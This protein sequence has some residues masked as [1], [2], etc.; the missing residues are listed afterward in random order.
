MKIIVSCRHRSMTKPHAQHTIYTNSQSPS[1]RSRWKHPLHHQ[2]KSI[3]L[4]LAFFLI[5]LSFFFVSPA[6]SYR[7]HY[8]PKCN[9][10]FVQVP[11]CLVCLYHTCS[12]SCKRG[13][14]LSLPPHLSQWEIL[15]T[16]IAHWSWG[17]CCVYYYTICMT[18]LQLQVVPEDTN[19]TCCHNTPLPKVNWAFFYTAE[20]ATHPH[21]ALTRAAEKQGDESAQGPSLFYMGKQECI[22]LSILKCF[23]RRCMRNGLIFSQHKMDD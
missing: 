12:L 9:Q 6:G 5:Y 18:I 13:P 3:I 8:L 10:L 4:L 17:N 19:Q 16:S 15:W 21:T 23:I 14:T 20:L 11:A 22:H 1:A 2:T 7:F